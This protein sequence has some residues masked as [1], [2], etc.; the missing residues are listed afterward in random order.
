MVERNVH[1]NIHTTIRCCH[2]FHGKFDLFGVA[3]ITRHSESGAAR[4]FDLGH[5]FLYV[6]RRDR[7][8]G[9]FC[10]LCCEE[11]GSGASDTA[12]R[13]RDDG[14]FSFKTTHL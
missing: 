12:T 3:Y 10:A 2:L 4:G 7:E 5:D 1:Q 6:G 13:T 8:N 11:F 9:D 14:N